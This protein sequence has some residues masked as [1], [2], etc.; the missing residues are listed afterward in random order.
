[1]NYMEIENFKSLLL[2]M[3]KQGCEVKS[4][5]FGVEGRAVGVGFKPYWTNP[6]DSKIDKIEFNVLD[7]RGRI[8]PFYLNNVIGCDIIPK[9]DENVDQSKKLLFDLHIFSPSKAREKE[10]YDKIAVEIYMK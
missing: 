6:G 1:M 10:P 4:H 3:V 5:T 9:D 7:K 8:M 2:K